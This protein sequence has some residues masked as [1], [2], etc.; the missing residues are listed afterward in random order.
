MSSS[1]FL[2]KGK[3]GL[4][5]TPIPSTATN[6]ASATKLFAPPAATPNVPPIN[7][8]MLNTYLNDHRRFSCNING[9]KYTPSSPSIDR[10]SPNEHAN[11]KTERERSAGLKRSVFG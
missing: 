7:N 1:Y 11:E 4:P 10:E 6:D 2:R 3:P 9:G 5:E 8:V